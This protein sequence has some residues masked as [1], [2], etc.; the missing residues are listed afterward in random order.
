MWSARLG[1][2]AADA[3]RRRRWSSGGRCGSARPRSDWCSSRRWQPHDSS[4]SSASRHI[5]SA[6]SRKSATRPA[7]SSAWLMPP[8]PSVT[9]RSR[10]N[11]S[12]MPRDLVQREP[13]PVGVAGDAALVEHQVA[14]LAV[15]LGSPG[16]VPPTPSSRSMRARTCD[17]A[18]SNAGCA[19][20]SVVVDLG[21][22]VGDGVRDDEVAVGQALH[23]RARAEPVGAV[24]GEVRLADREQARDRRLEPVV[25][26]EAAHRVVRRGVDPHR[27]LPRAL[28]R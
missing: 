9:R 25:D 6:S 11:S 21:Q 7:Y 17:S 23:H 14:E 3:P 19:A 28:G 12:R 5:S 18:S 27:D 13:Q 24:V 1:A 2:L 4:R 22:V 15:E 10:Q 26:P 16:V 8:A 20:S